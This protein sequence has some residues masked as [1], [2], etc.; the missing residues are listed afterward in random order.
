M[1][2]VR[3]F[4]SL[5]VLLC[6]SLS[7]AQPPSYAKQVKPFFAR[8]C[9]ECHNS[10]EG[11]GGLNLETF[12]ALMEGGGRGAAV[13]PGKPDGS[14]LVRMIE[15]KAKPFMP[16][17]KAKQ[18]P[19][20]EV[21]LVR[22]WVLAGAR[23][24]SSGAKVV[25]PAIA[26]KH[27]VATPVTAL[28]Y[29]AGGKYLA[30][31][32]RGEVLLL[33]PAS[34][35][36]RRRL[37]A[38]RD[39][40][41]ALAFS[42]KGGA[43]AAAAS[44]A[45]E[46]H[47]VR[48]WLAGPT[49]APQVYRHQDVIHDLAFS[50]DGKILASASYDR[51][52]QLWAV[53]AR[54]QLHVLKDHS[55][56]VYS[57]AFS[58]DG[59]M[60]A[61]AAADRAVKV[62][63]VRTGARLYTLSESTDWVYAVAWS[64]DGKRLAAAGVDRSIRVWEV[65][66]KGGR[67]VHSVFAH[68]GPLTRLLYSPDGKTLYSLSEDRSVKSWDAEKMV[69]RRVY[70]RQPETPLS[71]ALR[72][73]QKQLALGR[74]DGALVLLEESSGK[75]QGQ[76]LPVKPKPP[77]VEKVSPA[78]GVRGKAVE[79]R[80][81][82]RNL[83][84]ARVVSTI[85]GFTAT[86]S[87]D[88]RI[89][90]GVIPANTP[91][92]SYTL[93]MVNETGESKPQA[94]LVDRFSVLRENEPN[95][96]PRTGQKV[97][98]PA[99]LVGAMNRDGD[100][101]WFRFEAKAGQE[102]GV[103]ALTS[104]VGSK[105]E[106][107]LQLVDPEGN[108]VVESVTGVLGHRCVRTGTYSLGIRDREYRGGAGM[109]YRLH[110]GDIPVVTSVF[111]L[112]LRRGTEADIRVE[113]VYLGEAGKVR[114]KAPANAAPG[115]RLAVPLTTP[116]GPPLNAPSVVVGEFPEVAAGAKEGAIPIPGT[117]NGVI[118]EAGAKDVWRFE[119]RKGQRLLIE[120]SARRIGSLLDSTIEILDATGRP[121]P[122]ATLRCL[123]KTY[124]AFRDHDSGSPG[125]RLETW[126]EL[127]VNDYLLVGSELLR[128]KE[129]P[130]NPDDDCQFFAAQGQR[131]G[132]LG[133]T[134]TYQSQGS[135][136]Y[137]VGVHPPGSTFPAN[138]LPVVTMFWRNDD[139]GPGFGKD[140]RL[141][142]DPPADGTYRLRITD[143]RGEGSKEHAYRLTVRPPKPDF[144]VRFSVGGTVARGGAVTVRATAQRTDEFS[145][146]IALKLLDLPAG[147]S[148][149][150]T[151]IPAG[152]NRTAFALY[153]SPEASLGKKPI[154]LTLQAK[155]TVAG[156][157]VIRKAAGSLPGV[158]DPGDIVTT[159]GQGEVT[160]KPGGEARVTVKVQRRN[161]FKGRIPL[162]VQGLPHGVRVLD[163]GLNGILVIPGE[164]TR[165]IVLQAD[166]WV[167]PMRRP[168]VVLARHEGKGTEHAARSLTLRVAP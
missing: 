100:L 21:A 94:F 75:V 123:A 25:L 38:G 83:Q 126:S 107:V 19:R 9:V 23:D 144:S 46:A 127:A 34:G 20:D 93:R 18:P 138:G 84:G 154:P 14:R 168:F 48:V 61:S 40:V 153:A 143:A 161:G 99:T 112:G 39:R 47:E 27:K 87:A 115:T 117:A 58:P 45:G 121:L 64:P 136:M 30:A 63:D 79:I 41:T 130:R 24:D 15:G 72:P 81:E 36:L 167:Q 164:T 110:V 98:L 3:F 142:F 78:E 55:D 86:A 95:D 91:P 73:D 158:V 159:T 35:E 104:K 111:P 10:K 8:Y 60:L 140:S 71:L 134:P 28:A 114:V 50:P 152:E 133:T 56:A 151:S 67:V 65:D 141:V 160:L 131:L 77:V 119:A 43:F 135:P 166:S 70:A 109:H 62:W 148:A 129:L 54:K 139:G 85:P 120:V 37:P 113:G 163:V 42:P 165:T 118:A 51:L 90:R 155:A 49:G 97:T 105:L 44:T 106:P 132:F 137:K 122:R 96:S 80:F 157:E 69:E 59:T 102:V 92:G 7:Q 13:V 156:K 146:P 66:R 147:L 5:G 103:Q 11:E 53:G 124:V 108:A 12:K 68:E 33:D 32:G 74:Y 128:I 29:A 82:G 89:A 116:H 4:L 52:I 101:D 57:V 22:A 145:G 26:P 1:T 149:P 17:R 16:P 6:G 88:G 31:T 162:E 76:P 125:I 150:A 2:P